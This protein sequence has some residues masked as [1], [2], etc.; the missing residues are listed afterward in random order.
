MTFPDFCRSLGI[1][2]PE[3]FTIGKWQRCA[4]ITHERKRNASIK[5][6]DSGR[7]GWAVNFETG[8]SAE[9]WSD[10]NAVER[11]AEERA[12]DNAA[13]SERIA[14]RRGEEMLGIM[15]ARH[16]YHVATPLRFA[17]HEYLR[18]KRLDMTGC[19]GIKVDAEG[20]LV[21]PKQRDG[22]LVSIERIWPDGTKKSAY[23]APSKGASFKVWRPGASVTILCE[24][25]ATGLTIFA[26]VPQAVVIVCFSASN[27]IEVAKREE[28]KGMVAVASDNDH[29]TICQTHK[30]MGLTEPMDPCEERPDWC[31]CNPGKS[32]A[33][34]AA[35]GL[36]CGWAC[37]P[38]E[39]EGT[40]WHDWFLARLALLEEKD[41]ES[42]WPKS[43]FKLRQDALMPIRTAMMGAMKFAGSK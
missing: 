12:R 35:S 14:K 3:H 24:G 10:G 36:G 2:P 5:L 23:Q 27:L 17:N 31:L 18:R 11:T 34:V 30:D 32:A 22:K 8:K 38:P 9:T 39:I 7:I 20:A 40:D 13:L 21:I 26:A 1:I 25:F 15:R 19:A 28:W 4:T 37:S 16:A 29:F 42:Q 43:P 41:K 6:D 33:I